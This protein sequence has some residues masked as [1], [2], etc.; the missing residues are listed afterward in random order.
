MDF[1]SKVIALYS[2]YYVYNDKNQTESF[3]K[4]LAS[5]GRRR[6]I[7]LN[8]IIDKVQQTDEEIDRI[9]QR[10]QKSFGDWIRYV[11]ENGLD[12][13]TTPA[14]KEIKMT[15]EE[16]DQ[17]NKLT[18]E[19]ELFTEQFYYIAFRLRGIIR[20]LP[21]LRKFESPGM[22]DVRN[23]LIEHP[24]KDKDSQVFIQ[25]FQYGNKEI[26]PVIKGIRYSDQV[27]IFP[28]N[29]L[30]TNARELRENLENIIESFL[31]ESN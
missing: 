17:H 19:L 23:K 12:F 6:I 5:E 29:G 26:G 16:F 4:D 22:R 27:S 8:Y 9:S 2:E 30:Y 31:E 28:D 21:G 25:S 15:K 10:H 24:D 3:N 11:H 20:Y 7:Q 1:F 13:S 14:P 18:F